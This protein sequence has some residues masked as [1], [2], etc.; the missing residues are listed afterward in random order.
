MTGQDASATKAVLLLAFADRQLV[1]IVQYRMLT[2]LLATPER[3]LVI[4]LA[5]GCIQLQAQAIDDRHM[6]LPSASGE[7]ADVEGSTPDA[8]W[9]IYNPMTEWACC[10]RD[11]GQKVSICSH[12]LKVILMLQPHRSRAGEKTG[13]F[14]RTGKWR[15]AEPRT[16]CSLQTPTQQHCGQA[17]GQP[18]ADDSTSRGP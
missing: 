1:L 4:I 6:L 15:L 7:P 17:A 9:K 5:D 10:T 2:F 11:N 18:R 13:H 16:G 14:Q 12:Q 3:G 8:I